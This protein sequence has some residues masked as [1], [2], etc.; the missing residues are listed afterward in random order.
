[1]LVFDFERKGVS[2]DEFVEVLAAS[3]SSVSSNLN[4][5]LNLKIIK[6]FNKIDERKRFFVMNEDFMKIRFEELIEMMQRELLIIDNIKQIRDTK[7]EVAL[8]KF[9]I[10]RNL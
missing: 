1:Y 6:D 8:A 3:K 5:L 4:L 9:D 7:C 2:F 10:Y